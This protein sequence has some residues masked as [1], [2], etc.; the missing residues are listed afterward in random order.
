LSQVTVMFTRWSYCGVGLKETPVKYKMESCTC[1]SVLSC[2]TMTSHVELRK[3][4][5][6]TA[7]LFLVRSLFSA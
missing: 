2:W 7:T 5:R 1:L 6:S 3:V 4:W